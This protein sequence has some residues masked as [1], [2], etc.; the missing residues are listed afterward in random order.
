MGLL[1]GGIAKIVAGATKLVTYA[2]SL[3][4][5]LGTAG[6]NAWE[7]GTTTDTVY[8]CLGC[9]VDYKEY[10][11]DGKK[12]QQGDRQIIVIANSLTTVPLVGDKVTARGETYEV[13]HSVADPALATYLL[14][15]R[16]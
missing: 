11:I 9:V 8:P 6:S 4:R 14:Q 3:T 7:V 13:V 1:D 2:I 12:I 15:V 5:T 16:R 10:Q